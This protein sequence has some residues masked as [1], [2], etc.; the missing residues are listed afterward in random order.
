MDQVAHLLLR[1]AA[2][3]ASAARGRLLGLAYPNHNQPMSAARVRLAARARRGPHPLR[4]PR[5]LPAAQAPPV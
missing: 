4:L 1:G 2:R 5:L 3:S